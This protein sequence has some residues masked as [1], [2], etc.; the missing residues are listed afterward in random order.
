ML[1]VA[2]ALVAGGFTSRSADE[3]QVRRWWEEHPEA[4]PAIVPGDAALA[5][6]D[7]DSAGAAQAV[8]DAGVSLTD[9]FI[10]ATGGTSAPF[11][12]E[13]GELPP[14]HVY[15]AAST[16][17]KLKGVVARYKAGYVIA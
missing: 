11:P 3:I 9:G 6:L 4:L 13:G 10:V 14:M 12:F 17:P 5:A 7:V 1:C 8:R 16:Q 15:L 2:L